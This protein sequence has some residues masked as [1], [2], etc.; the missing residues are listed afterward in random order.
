MFTTIALLSVGFV[1]APAVRAPSLYRPRLGLGANRGGAAVYSRGERVRLFFRLDQDAY[2]TIFRVD[3]DGRVRVL[4]PRD[5]WEDNFARGGRDLAVDGRELGSDAFTID[6]YPG[7]GYLFAVASAD[8]FVYDQIESG[9][10]WDYRS[11]A[12]GRGRGDPY[13]AKTDL[14]T[15]SGPEAYSE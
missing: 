7:V 4:F 14:A 2:V 5:P 10:H 11:I 15:R 6:D 3:P 1:S 9:D 13:A 12:D 8:A